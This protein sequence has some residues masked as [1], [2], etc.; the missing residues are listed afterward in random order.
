[1]I[2]VLFLILVVMISSVFAQTQEQKEYYKFF[3]YKK[4]SVKLLRE[5]TQ[6]FCAEINKTGLVGWIVNYGM[7]EE[8]S[9]REKQIMKASENY[10][11]G[12]E[13]PS[14]RITFVKG[15]EKSKSRTVFWLVSPEKE[16][17]IN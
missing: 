9:K 14:P 12:K 8:I 1:M 3:E 10:D 6:S 2:R 15:G 5:R 11:C 16:P 17:P 7:P 4:I 13:F